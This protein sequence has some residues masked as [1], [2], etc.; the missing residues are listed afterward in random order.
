MIRKRAT[1]V[2]PFFAGQWTK[3]GRRIGRPAVRWEDDL[4]KF[5]RA[6]GADW[7]ML[8]QDRGSWDAEEDRYVVF[9][10]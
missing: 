4:N 2:T 6:I 9:T 8:A 7:R 10:G 3:G 1:R 5:G